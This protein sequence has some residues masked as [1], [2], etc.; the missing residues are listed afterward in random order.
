MILKRI[1]ALLCAAAVLASFDSCGFIVV[2]DISSRESRG[3]GEGEEGEGTETA[4]PSTGYVKYTDRTDAKAVSESYLN[5]LPERDYEG[6]VFFVATPSKG[7]FAPD[8]RSSATP[9]GRRS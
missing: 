6:A 3:E 7:Y 2:N 1:L 8:W 5:S 4:R 9:R